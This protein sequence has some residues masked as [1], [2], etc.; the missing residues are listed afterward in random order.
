[1]ATV[2]VSVAGTRTPPVGL[3]SAVAVLV[4]EPR[5]RSAPLTRWVAVQV[6]K[7]AGARL[8]TG[9]VM[10]PSLSSLTARAL[11]VTLPVLVTRYE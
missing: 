7:A 10:A 5:S 11:I 3:P 2:R 6:V 9:Q 1:M 8:L 4:M